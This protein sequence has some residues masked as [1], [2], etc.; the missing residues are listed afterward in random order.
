M[1]GKP[2]VGFCVLAFKTNNGLLSCSPAITQIPCQTDPKNRNQ[3]SYKELQEI[4]VFHTRRRIALQLHPFDAYNALS[5]F[6]L[7][8]LQRLR[9][10]ASKGT[11]C[12]KRGPPVRQGQ[13][14]DKPADDRAT[15]LSMA[16]AAEGAK[17]LLVEVLR[18]LRVPR[19]RWEE[20]V[21][22]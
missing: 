11:Q 12:A 18:G 19:M 17:G 14:F 21:D 1:N 16:G 9:A 20:G 13:W 22:D 10:S 8:S 2:A 5:C 15:P 6:Y 7:T 4:R 3:L